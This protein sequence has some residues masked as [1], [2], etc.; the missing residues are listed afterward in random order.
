MDGEGLGQPGAGQVT[1]LCILDAPAGALN[2]QPTGVRW[3]AGESFGDWGNR[4]PRPAL[5]GGRPHASSLQLLPRGER[6]RVS[7]LLAL[8]EKEIQICA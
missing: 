5:R 7:E 3:G 6:P 2:R 8:Q 4:E 1:A